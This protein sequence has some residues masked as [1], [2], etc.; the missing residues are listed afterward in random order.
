MSTVTVLEGNTM[1]DHEKKST[2]PIRLTLEALDAARIAASL[3]GMSVLDY[4]SEILLER[5]T[6]ESDQWSLARAEA[7]RAVARAE[8]NMASAEVMRAEALRRQEEVEKAASR[9][10][11]DQTAAK[12]K[13]GGK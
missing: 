9:A 13:A 2:M 11:E 8:M 6:Q 10:R 5:A 1:V 3:K 7:S 4:A 12:K